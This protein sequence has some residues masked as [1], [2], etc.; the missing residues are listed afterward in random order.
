MRE[1]GQLQIDSVNVYERAHYLPLL[2]RLGPYPK[3]ALDSL[4]GSHSVEYWPH[5]AG[6]I[7]IEDWPLW[8]WRRAEFAASKRRHWFEA[9]RS[10]ADWVLGELAERGPVTAGQI[11]HDRNRASGAWWGWSE[12]KIALE[13]LWR[14]GEVVCVRRKNFERL[15]E[16]P[17]ALP[18]IAHAEPPTPAAAQLILL[19]RA[20]RAL[21]VFVE[22]DLADYW[23]MPVA[24][25]RPLLRDLQES[26]A[27]EAVTVAGWVTA[28]GRP[29]P[30]WI[31][32]DAA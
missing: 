21:G 24:T 26:G 2:S 23:R 32:R 3:T 29:I 12:V 7:P 20:A 8:E 15:Y 28:A 10:L 18:A 27:V 19:E 14:T 31:H 17:S 5:Q 9:N 13:Y 30:A 1:L 22:A 16:L 4:A 25:V 6:L 11:E